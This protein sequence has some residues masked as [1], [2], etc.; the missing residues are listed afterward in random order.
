MSDNSSKETSKKRCPYCQ[1]ELKFLYHS[2][3]PTHD[4]F[5][6]VDKNEY[7]SETTKRKKK[8]KFK[9]LIKI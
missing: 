2:I 1:G 7:I 6:C 4:I 3:S 9:G 5:E 8:C